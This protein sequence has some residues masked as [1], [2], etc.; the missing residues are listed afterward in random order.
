MELMHIDSLLSGY[1]SRGMDL[2]FGAV[3]SRKLI[4]KKEKRYKQTSIWSFFSK[5]PIENENVF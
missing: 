3:A 4:L 1:M 5:K 2:L